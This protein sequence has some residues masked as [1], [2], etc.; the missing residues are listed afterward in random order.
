MRVC[1][2]FLLLHGLRASELEVFLDQ[3]SIES[4]NHLFPP[5]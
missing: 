1:V 3:H 5:P 2:F 4:G